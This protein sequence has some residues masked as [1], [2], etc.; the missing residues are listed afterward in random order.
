MSDKATLALTINAKG[1]EFNVKDFGATGDG[2][3][4]DTAAVQNAVNAACEI[5]GTVVFPAGTYLCNIAL[6]NSETGVTMLGRGSVTN[7]A[8]LSTGTILRPW[9]K[10]NSVISL[11]DNTNNTWNVT[12]K[13][14]TVS[15]DA[16]TTTSHGLTLNGVAHFRASNFTVSEMGGDGIQIFSGSTSDS[17][18]EYIYFD[19]ISIFNCMGNGLKAIYPASGGWVTSVYFSNFNIVQGQQGAS[20]FAIWNDGC[21]LS[22]ANGWIQP[23][24]G[25]TGVIWVAQSNPNIPMFIFSNVDLDTADP[26]FIFNFLASTDLNYFPSSYVIGTYHSKGT[27]KYN[28]GVSAPLHPNPRTIES[29]LWFLMQ[30]NATNMGSQNPGSSSLPGLTVRTVEGANFLEL[31]NTGFAYP[32]TWETPL[33]STGPGKGGL[34]KNET[35][36]MLRWRSDASPIGSDEDGGGIAYSPANIVN[37]GLISTSPITIASFTPP[38]STYSSIGF[39]NYL[40]AVHFHVITA[41]TTITANVSYKDKSG[42]AV[43]VP[44]YTNS[45]TSLGSGASMGVGNVH[46]QPLMVVAD[47]SQAIEVTATAGIANQVHASASIVALS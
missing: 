23:A 8:A 14:L 3:T 16:T 15:G 21:E 47:P 39:Q 4:N 2:A 32:F 38:T 29:A 36:G 24:P 10:T 12:I 34:W 11:G 25:S 41:A 42:N 5:G 35:T 20:N 37:D 44:V 28:D 45:G 19:R 1:G 43:T 33:F 31:M 22:F 9:D 6:A 7:G 26:T 13:D 40:V 18:S 27:V 30:G 46:C 17:K